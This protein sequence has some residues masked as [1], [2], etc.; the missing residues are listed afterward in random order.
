[1]NAKYG[2]L[3]GNQSNSRTEESEEEE[4]EQEKNQSQTNRTFQNK[5]QVSKIIAKEKTTIGQSDISTVKGSAS[6]KIEITENEMNR[7]TFYHWGASR[8]I[9]EIIRRRRE[10]PDTRRLVERRET[11]ARPGTMQI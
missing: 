9:M 10:N 3:F 5:N 6:P 2:S 8:E 1:M 4:N 7:E 11:L